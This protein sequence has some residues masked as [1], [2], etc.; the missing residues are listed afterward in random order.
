MSD[1]HGFFRLKSLELRQVVNLI[2]KVL[3]VRRMLVG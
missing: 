2:Y 3:A 1:P